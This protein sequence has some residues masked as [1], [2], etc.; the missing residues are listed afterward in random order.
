MTTG[1][2]RAG[3]GPDE[4]KARRRLAEQDCKHMLQIGKIL[5]TYSTYCL[6]PLYLLYRLYL[7]YLLYLLLPTYFYLLLPTYF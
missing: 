7:L 4:A 1:Y 2:V 6:I 5:S 3:Q